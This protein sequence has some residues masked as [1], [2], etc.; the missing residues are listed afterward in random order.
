MTAI[1]ILV[2]I[3]LIPSHR[4]SSKELEEG[5]LSSFTR[6]QFEM[7]G[8]SELAV[9]TLLVR[10]KIVYIK[11]C[12]FLQVEREERVERRIQDI[13]KKEGKFRGLRRKYE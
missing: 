3:P 2:A 10:Y 5:R 6:E 11:Q 12:I 1:S 13:G 8:V 9:V 7:Q 4:T